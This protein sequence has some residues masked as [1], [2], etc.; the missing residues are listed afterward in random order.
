MTSTYA[1]IVHLNEC[2]SSYMNCAKAS[3]FDDPFFFSSGL[4]APVNQNRW[5]NSFTVGS[6]FKVVGKSPVHK[7]AGQVLLMSN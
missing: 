1:C 5:K 3:G 6:I 4:Q 2:I 7:Q